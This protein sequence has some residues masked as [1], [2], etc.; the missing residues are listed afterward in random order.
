MGLAGSEVAFVEVDWGD[1]L[2][3]ADFTGLV[4]AG[5]ITGTPVDRDLLVKGGPPLVWDRSRV[6]FDVVAEPLMGAEGLRRGR[7]VAVIGAGG[8]SPPA[9]FWSRERALWRFIEA[10][11][12]AA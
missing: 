6:P 10:A 2:I 5:L 11:V 12:G 8:S 4:R 3:D 9:G 7:V 1:F